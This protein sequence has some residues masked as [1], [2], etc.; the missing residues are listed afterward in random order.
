MFSHLTQ[1]L[2][3]TSTPPPF[4]VLVQISLKLYS[5]QAADKN[6]IIAKNA[7]CVCVCGGGAGGGVCGCDARLL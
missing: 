4:F 5:F 1:G 7:C 6:K 2:P 3:N